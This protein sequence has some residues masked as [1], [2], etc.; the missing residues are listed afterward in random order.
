[1][2]DT[3]KS[4]LKQIPELI[5]QQDYQ[6]YAIKFLIIGH[7]KSVQAIAI[8]I[9]LT[10]YLSKKL[11]YTLTL[12]FVVVYGNCCLTNISSFNRELFD[13]N[14]KEADTGIV[15]HALDVHKNDPFTEI[16]IACSDAG[17]LLIMLNLRGRHQWLHNLQNFTPGVLL[18]RDLKKFQTQYH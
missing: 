10:E 4:G 13:N 18:K 17:V 5:T 2:I 16:V 9:E 14:Q 12:D 11:H 7:L 6:L 15:L 3:T 1:M 8:K